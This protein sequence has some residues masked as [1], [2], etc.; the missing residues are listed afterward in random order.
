MFF[1]SLFLS[2]PSCPHARSRGYQAYSYTTSPLSL[3]KD[4]TQQRRQ[5][6]RYY[7]TQLRSSVHF[8]FLPKHGCCFRALGMLF[9]MKASRVC[10][11]LFFGMG[12]VCVCGAF[13]LLG[14]AACAINTVCFLNA[15]LGVNIVMGLTYLFVRPF[16][17]S[18]VR[19]LVRGG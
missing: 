9:E 1:C 16:S 11:S 2:L 7:C 3:T 8:F 18:A 5:I 17:A 19:R 12:G 4:C 14:K 15:S 10:F 6:S 13:R